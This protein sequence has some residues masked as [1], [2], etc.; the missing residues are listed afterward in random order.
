MIGGI[1]GIGGGSILAPI[2][3]AL[4]FTVYDIAGAALAATFLTSIAGVVTFQ[5]LELRER[6][7]QHRARLGRR[8]GHRRRRAGRQL[9]GARLQ[10][11]LPEALIRRGLGLVVVLV[12]VRY[13]LEG[14]GVG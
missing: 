2:L 4:G 7:R 12:A 14:L 10:P 6:R 8:P 1:Y 13:L 5:L 3:L 9:P 11:H